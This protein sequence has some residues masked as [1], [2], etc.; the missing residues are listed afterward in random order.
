MKTLFLY[1]GWHDFIVSHFGIVYSLI[2]R[3]TDFMRQCYSVISQY[4]ASPA[5]VPA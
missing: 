3:F 1:S 2:G 4:S 5:L